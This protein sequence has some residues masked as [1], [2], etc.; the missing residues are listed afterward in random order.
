[1][2]IGR[3]LNKFINIFTGLFA[4]ITIILMLVWYINHVAGGILLPGVALVT[5]ER[6]RN[7]CMLATVFCGG[8]EFTLKRNI[9]LAIIFACIVVAVAL[10]MIYSDVTAVPVSTDAAEQTEAVRAYLA[11]LR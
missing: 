7:Y 1:M 5:I 4:I 2:V 9:I 6:V 8:I 3:I 10:F 11:A